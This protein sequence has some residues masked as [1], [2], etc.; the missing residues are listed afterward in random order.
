MSNVTNLLIIGTD[1]IEFLEPINKWI[2]DN[3]G[4]ERICPL[5]SVTMKRID[6]RAGGNKAMETHILA[7]AFT[8]FHYVTPA[9]I[10][11]LKTLKWTSDTDLLVK[12]D[13]HDDDY[14]RVIPLRRT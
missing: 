3:Y 8:S 2:W 7:A 9:F 4:L 1:A 5:E 12:E 6:H 10:D 11:F 14:F 13:E